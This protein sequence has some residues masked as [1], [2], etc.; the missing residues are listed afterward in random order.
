MTSLACWWQGMRE[1]S[2]AEQF[3]QVTKVCMAACRGT[4]VCHPTSLA[5]PCCACV[6]WDGR[7]GTATGWGQSHKPGSS[8]LQ[9]CS[10]LCLCP[11]RGQCRG[12][13][14]ASLPGSLWWLSHELFQLSRRLLE[15]QMWPR[16]WE[17]PECGA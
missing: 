13:R 5:V 7:L 16:A 8:S 12:C 15:G 2:S 9:S 1:E 6:P 3:L 11:R 14:L 10:S 17:I 4:S